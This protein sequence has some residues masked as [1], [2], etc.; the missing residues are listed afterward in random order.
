MLLPAQAR[1]YP[2]LLASPHDEALFEHYMTSELVL[3]SVR[4]TA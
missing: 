2:D 1:T 4:P 3:V